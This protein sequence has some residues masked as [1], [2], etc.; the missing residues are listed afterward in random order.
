MARPPFRQSCIHA[1]DNECT[2]Q[3]LRGKD[4]VGSSVRLKLRK[5]S[6]KTFECTIQRGS[7]ARI[8]AIGDLFLYLTEVLSNV[9]NN[10]KVATVDI[11]GCVAD[12]F[13]TLAR[14]V[15]A[16]KQAVR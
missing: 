4:V 2:L 7:I 6:G 5:P 9:E 10:K 15:F 1:N 8:E 12:Q 3:A 14:I 16:N 13:Y 11:I